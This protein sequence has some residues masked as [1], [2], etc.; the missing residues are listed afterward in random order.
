VSLYFL[1]PALQQLVEVSLN[2]LATRHHDRVAAGRGHA[3]PDETEFDLWMGP[4]GVGLLFRFD[5]T[6]AD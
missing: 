6:A 3:Q 5:E 2:A 1:S 4:Q